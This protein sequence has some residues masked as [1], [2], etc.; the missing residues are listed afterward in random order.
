MSPWEE[1]FTHTRS[2][3]IENSSNMKIYEVIFYGSLGDEPNK[4]RIYLVRAPD[5]QS[6]V[7]EVANNAPRAQHGDDLRRIAHIVYEVGADLSPFPETHPR[8]LR[9]PYI[10][11][12]YNRG[13]KAW[14]RKD[15]GSEHSYEW[16]E[17]G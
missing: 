3:T 9:G 6:A 15:R 7:E 14:K 4:D 13:W 12:A 17:L 5:F 8:I 1:R 16:E 11:S 10:E 2:L